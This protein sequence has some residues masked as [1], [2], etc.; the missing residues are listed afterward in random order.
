MNTLLFQPFK[1]L[2]LTVLLSMSCFM[3]FAQNPFLVKQW[4][5]RYGGTDYEYLLSLRQTDDSGFILGGYSFSG[6]SGDKTEPS[7]DNHGTFVKAIVVKGSGF[8]SENLIDIKNLAAGLYAYL[9]VANVNIN[10]VS[11][12]FLIVK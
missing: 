4:D 5:Y 1:K 12:K 11:C 8:Y 10:Q 2:L 6:I 7:H 9:I 3:L